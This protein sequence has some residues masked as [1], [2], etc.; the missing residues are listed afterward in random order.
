MTKKLKQTQARIP[1]IR[2]GLQTRRVSEVHLVIDSGRYCVSELVKLMVSDLIKSQP[3]SCPTTK[4][5]QE[6]L[7]RPFNL[8]TG[9]LS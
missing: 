1:E 7:F 4:P 2:G 6:R 9:N 3:P 8:G 5:A